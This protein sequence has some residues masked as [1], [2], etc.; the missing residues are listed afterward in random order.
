[1][2]VRYEHIVAL[3]ANAGPGPDPG[4]AARRLRRRWTEAGGNGQP[5]VGHRYRLTDA[6]AGA[7]H[8]AELEFGPDIKELY[9]DDTEIPIAAGASYGFDNLALAG[10]RGVQAPRCPAFAFLLSWQVRQPYAP[11]GL[12][13]RIQTLS[14]DN[15][16]EI[17][18]GAAGTVSV[19][20][21]YVQIVNNS[22]VDVTVE[23]RYGFG[24]VQG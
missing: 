1:M 13:L 14:M 12:D 6:D 9:R 8:A 23:M 21:A 19:G 18:S 7:P 4:G 2:A 5:W 11:D 17:A 24:E 22:D 20:C 15:P 10:K 16:T 3:S